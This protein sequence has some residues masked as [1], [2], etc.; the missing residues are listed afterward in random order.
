MRWSLW[1]R[2]AH[3][4]RCHRSLSRAKGALLALRLRVVDQARLQLRLPG[5]CS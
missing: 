5:L 3:H 2:L 1:S 4:Q